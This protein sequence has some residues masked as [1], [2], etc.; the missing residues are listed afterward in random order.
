MNAIVYG[1]YGH[2]ANA[3]GRA[4]HQAGCGV[5][6]I[7]RMEDTPRSLRDLY[8]FPQ[9]KFLSKPFYA[10]SPEQMSD[11]VSAGLMS[12]MVRLS[13]CLRI[14]AAQ[15]TRV[16]YVIIGSTSSY[17]G[18]TETAVYCAVK[19]ALV[20]LVQALND[21]YKNTNRRFW[22]FSPGTMD[23]DMGRQVTDQDP[24]T[25]LSPDDVAEQI[26]ATVTNPSNMF[27]PEI[28]IRRRTVR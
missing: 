2:L 23:T 25:F 26:V 18:F 17:Q 12:I 19:H 8:V 5:Q 22:L 24:S 13:E 7:G 16:D 15:D 10:T 9:G 6:Q 3:L 21:E 1:E 20:G 4:F 11:V 28:V 14:P 27:Q